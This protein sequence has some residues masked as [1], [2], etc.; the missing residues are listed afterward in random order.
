MV[1]VKLPTFAPF[2]KL[3]VMR[4]GLPLLA[5]SHGTS[6]TVNEIMSHAELFLSLPQ[7]AK[8]ATVANN[9]IIKILFFI[10]I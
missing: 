4:M 1:G 3:L 6:F 2:G 8:I 9:A 7:E 5:I 10:D